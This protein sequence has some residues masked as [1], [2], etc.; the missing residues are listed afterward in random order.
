MGRKDCSRFGHH[1]QWDDRL[2]FCGSWKSVYIL[3]RPIWLP[4]AQ[5]IK[6]RIY[7]FTCRWVSH[8]RHI[9]PILFEHFRSPNAGPILVCVLLRRMYREKLSDSRYH[10][11]LFPDLFYICP[12]AVSQLKDMLIYAI[13]GQSEY[14][15]AFCYIKYPRQ[16]LSLRK[17]PQNHTRLATC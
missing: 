9:N 12:D 13:G 2:L 15:S 11:S 16:M 6:I 1:E 5:G 8:R 10:N 14:H 7:P 17:I 3:A 4:W